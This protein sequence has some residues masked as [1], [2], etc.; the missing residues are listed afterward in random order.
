MSEHTDGMAS[1]VWG[2]LE[3]EHELAEVTRALHDAMQGS[4]GFLLV[5]G[6][7]GIGKSLLLAA[8]REAA[9][10]VGMGVISARAS[11]LERDFAF[12]VVRQLFE[13]L[14]VATS[15]QKRDVL[16]QGPA[17]HSQEVFSP[18]MSS[19]EPVG[20]FAVLHGLYWLTANACQ[21]QPHLLLVDDLQWCDVPSLRYLTY[22][23]PRIGDF[24]ILI[25]AALRSRERSA[26]ERLVRQ[27]AS[28]PAVVVLHPGDLSAEATTLLLQQALPGRV[29]PRFAEACYKATGGNPLLL[30][31]LTRTINAEGFPATANSAA[32][33]AALGKRAVARL[34]AVRLSRLSESAVILA[35]S[36]AVLGQSAP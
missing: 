26:D 28:D 36:V 3:R 8:A 5:E 10:E 34:V 22:L 11:E 6:A 9:L 21:E 18:S 4:G 29:D 23:L 32:G 15:E 33:V 27:I 35:R 12:G 13:P 7:P 25:V 19:V 24:R 1:A 30:R 31:E 16:L 20:D 14:L 2:L 17:V